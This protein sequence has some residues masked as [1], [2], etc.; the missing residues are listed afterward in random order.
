MN[1]TINVTTHWPTVEVAVGAMD[2]V[3]GVETSNRRVEGSEEIN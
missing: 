2:M 1:T 3:C